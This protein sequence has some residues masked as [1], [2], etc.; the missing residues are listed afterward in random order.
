MPESILVIAPHPDDEALGC[1]GTLCLHHHRG[2]TIHIIFL[3]SGD[4]GIQG[5]PAAQTRAIRE[6]EAAAS[7]F[8]L[9]AA[10]VDFLRLP[11]RS[12]SDHL[13]A[14]AAALRPLILAYRPN[15]IY[16]PHPDESHPDHAAAVPVVRAALAPDFPLHPDHTHLR[17]YEV[18]TP[19]LKPG[20]VE[21]I[22]PV[23]ATKLRA[24]RCHRSQLRALRYDRAILALNRYRGLMLGGTRYAEAFAYLPLN[25]AVPAGVSA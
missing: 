17:V 11:D 7:A 23:M 6:A 13:P 18:W 24:L 25:P 16:L 5:T 9:S 12:V 19:M 21:D 10:T 2:D 1:G 4:D 3:T 8:I 20:W 14:G 15:V 22:A